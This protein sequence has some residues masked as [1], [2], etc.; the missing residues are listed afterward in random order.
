[1]KYAVWCTGEHELYDLNVD[2]F[3]MNNLFDSQ[4]QQTNVT[5]IRLTNRLNALLYV[6]KSCC[7]PTCRDPWSALHGENT[8]VK[9]LA[10]ALHPKVRISMPF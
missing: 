1:M 8:P 7:G 6:L 2:P 4:Q 10:D 3:E 5:M 9:S